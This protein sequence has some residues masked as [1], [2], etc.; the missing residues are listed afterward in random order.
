MNKK[1]DSLNIIFL[2]VTAILS[3]AEGWKSIKLFDDEK[4]QWLHK[5]ITFENGIPINDTITK[6]ASYLDPQEL[7]Y[8][9][10]RKLIG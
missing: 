3:E 9:F 2:T 7:I 1:H 10:M 8:C 6:S 5:F 4:L